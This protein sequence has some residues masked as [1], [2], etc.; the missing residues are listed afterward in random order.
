MQPAACSAMKGNDSLKGPNSR[1]HA[2]CCSGRIS[3]L[4]Y[5]NYCS[6]T[7][8]TYPESVDQGGF[9]FR[10]VLYLGPQIAVSSKSEP[11]PRK[12]TDDDRHRWKTR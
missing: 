12:D 8:K 7:R 4:Y 2:S 3:K 6:Q 1:A 5:I 9:A 10:R 11:P